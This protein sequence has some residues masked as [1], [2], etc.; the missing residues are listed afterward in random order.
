[1]LL[2]QSGRFP[3]A[4]DQ[5][6]IDSEGLDQNIETTLIIPA[7]NEERRI[8][9]FLTTLMQNIPNSAEILVVCDGDDNTHLLAASVSHRIRILRFDHRLGKGGAILEGFKA[10]KGNVV[11]FVDAD[12]AIEPDEVFRISSMVS[13]MNPVVIGSRWVRSSVIINPEPI[14]NRVASRIFHYL[15]F[16]ILGVKEKDT[17]CG[18][19][20]FHGSIVDL[21]VN[22]VTVTDWIIDVALLFHVKLLGEKIKEVGITWKHQDNSKFSL[23]KAVPMM[24]FS[25]FGLRLANSRRYGEKFRFLSNMYSNRNND[26]LHKT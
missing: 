8:G 6:T 21:I 18:L 2:G 14:I 23:L 1:M 12:G 5:H 19:K 16:L 4:C 17:Q 15:V 13:E 25:L 20:F 10:A 7:F 24:F 22:R 9:P 11:G 26:D 3:D